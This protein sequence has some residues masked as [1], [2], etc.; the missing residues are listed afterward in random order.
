[1]PMG[2]HPVY[3]LHEQVSFFNGETSSV[4]TFLEVRVFRG[5]AATRTCAGTTVVDQADKIEQSLL[6]GVRDGERCFR[7]TR[8]RKTCQSEKEDDTEEHRL[9]PGN[10]ATPW[11]SLCSV[12]TS[13]LLGD[14][15]ALRSCAQDTRSWSKRSASCVVSFIMCLN[16][17][18]S[19]T[20]SPN[21]GIIPYFWMRTSFRTFFGLCTYRISLLGTGRYQNG[22]RELV[23]ERR[24]RYSGRHLPWTLVAFVAWECI[25]FYFLK[26]ACLLDSLCFSLVHLSFFSFRLLHGCLRPIYSPVDV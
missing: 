4:E 5:G 26:S 9:A 10:G 15:S 24:I 22:Q 2:G 14:M 25:I 1:M 20:L 17:I 12:C 13:S 19:F 8:W 16:G 18:P 21:T 3:S 6:C 23:R 11:R 7:R